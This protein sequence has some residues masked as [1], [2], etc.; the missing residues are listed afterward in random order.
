[1]TDDQNR[2]P[3]DAPFESADSADAPPAVEEKIA[4]LEILRQSLEESKRNEG[5][6]RDRL[7]RTLADFD[8]FR[9]RAEARISAARTYGREEV[10]FD[11]LTLG[12]ALDQALEATRKAADAQAIQTG[13]ALVHQQFEKFLTEHGL[14]AIP[15][16]GEKLDPNR[17][18]ALA[19]ERTD[20][21]PDGVI[22][23]E[24]QRG[25]VL[26]DRVVRTA[27]VRVASHPSEAPSEASPVESETAD[28][29][30]R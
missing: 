24:F 17:H 22:V 19:R 9:K 7:L 13:V 27:K 29:G 25:Y 14:K 6:L 30:N 5:E 1:M 20:R 26:G 21:V 15:T 3:D 2:R 8:N 4:E 23:A 11:L 18:E 28:E 12:D 10:I 16:V